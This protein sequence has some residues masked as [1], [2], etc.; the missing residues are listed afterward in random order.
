MLHKTVTR[1]FVHWVIG[2]VMLF[3]FAGQAMG[4]RLTIRWEKS[5]NT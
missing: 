5:K 3:A 1:R 2:I 4:R